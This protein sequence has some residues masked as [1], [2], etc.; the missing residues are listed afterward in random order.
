LTVSDSDWPE[1]GEELSRKVLSVLE[2]RVY[3]YQHGSIDVNTLRVTVRSLYDSITGLVSWD[4]ANILA[5]VLKGLP[6]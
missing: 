4:V 3:D 2:D 5:E 6:K 1:L